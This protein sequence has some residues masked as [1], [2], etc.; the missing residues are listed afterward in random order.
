[1]MGQI[2]WQRCESG[3]LGL[4]LRDAPDK[5][6]VH[7]TRHPARVRDG[8]PNMCSPGWTTLCKLV[9]QGWEVLPKLEC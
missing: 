8:N 2:Q 7:Y 4:H 1:M 9:R 6:W 3:D 5:P